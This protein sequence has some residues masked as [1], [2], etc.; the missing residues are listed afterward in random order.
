MKIVSFNIAGMQK[1]IKKIDE[2]FKNYDF[3]CLQETRLSSDL[4]YP[5]FKNFTEFH[6][7]AN[8]KGEKGVSILINKN[9]GGKVKE[10]YHNSFQGD[11]GRILIIEINLPNSNKS[12]FLF[13]AYL[14]YVSNAKNTKLIKHKRDMLNFIR[15]KINNVK[16]HAYVLLCMDGNI[17]RSLDEYDIYPSH[18]KKSTQPSFRPAEIK[19]YEDFDYSVDGDL[20]D[21]QREIL[22][23]EINYTYFSKRTTKKNI[24]WE[25]N[26]GLINDFMFLSNKLEKNV[27][28][29]KI[30]YSYRLL[31]DHCPLVLELSF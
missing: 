10:K 17:A 3:L 23:D 16:D 2:L 22:S 18:P 21:V 27:K 20:F 5:L 12:F 9:F 1:K 15:S 29:F 11:S 28:D 13:N 30:D 4:D 31:S 8:E 14:P 26:L 24:M 19:I 7:L 6:A 25:K